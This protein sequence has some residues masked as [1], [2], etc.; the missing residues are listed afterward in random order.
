[1]LHEPA[2][3]IRPMGSAAENTG[4]CCR[5]C[6]AVQV[7]TVG[8][9]ARGGRCACHQLYGAAGQRDNRVFGGKS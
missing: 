1:M 6:V 2:G 4:N 5:V 9:Y 3:S 8:S 7:L